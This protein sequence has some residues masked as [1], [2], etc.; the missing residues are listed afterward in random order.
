MRKILLLFILIFL[1]GCSVKEQDLGAGEL[2]VLLPV[3]GGTGTSTAVA[4]DIGKALTIASANPLTYQFST[5]TGASSTILADNNHWS[6]VNFFDG[7]LHSRASST[8]GS[9]I[10]VLGN[11]SAS[12]SLTTPSLTSNSTGVGVFT[13][14]NSSFSVNVAGAVRSMSNTSNFI[15]TQQTPVDSLIISNIAAGSARVVLNAAVPLSISTNNNFEQI[16]LTSNGKNVAFGGTS[17]ADKLTIYEGNLAVVNTSTAVTSTLGSNFFV[18]ASSTSDRTGKFYVDSS[19]NTSASGTLIS[20]THTIN[21]GNQTNV[22]AV[23]I[24]SAGQGTSGISYNLNAAGSMNWDNSANSLAV[25]QTSF[26]FSLTNRALNFVAN[27]NAFDTSPYAFTFQNIA[28]TGRGVAALQAASGQTADLLGMFNSAGNKLSYF[29]SSGYL[30]LGNGAAT[31]TFTNNSITLA[32]S[33]GFNLG[34]FNVDSSGNLS[35]SGTTYRFNGGAS[36]TTTINVGAL[37]TATSKACFNAQNT[38]G[39]NISF[40]F[41]GT[42]LTVE[43]NA[44]R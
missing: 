22:Q 8:F 6:S 27:G 14:P 17:A 24:L 28:T 25:A 5:V 13:A 26:R 11:I 23:N 21:Q 42:T 19:G 44:C 2:R 32:T 43:N 15:A 3:Q 30:I 35:A 4:G 40:Y 9:N 7:G 29:D 10:H 12:S 18:I 20:G 37:G 41:V 38:A 1:A 16:V 34:K 39:T 31:S 33:T 36:A